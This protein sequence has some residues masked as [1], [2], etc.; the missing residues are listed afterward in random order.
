MKELAARHG[1]VAEDPLA[2]H[3]AFPALPVPGLAFAVLRF[4][5]PGGD[6]IGRIA[7]HAEQSIARYNTGRNA[8][9]L[10]A[11]PGA[12]PTPPGGV[13]RRD[14]N[15][16]YAVGDGILSVWQRRDWN[17]NGGLGKMDELLSAAL[18]LASG[19]AGGL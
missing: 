16:S 13:R 8:V 3:R 4:T 17:A 9:L 15:L 5:P 10:Q 2:Y 7:W 19:E 11:A 18:A 12:T 6:G 1:A 14:L